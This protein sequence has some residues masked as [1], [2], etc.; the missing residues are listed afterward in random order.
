MTLQEW[1]EVLFFNTARLDWH[2]GLRR[3]PAN[4]LPMV[5]GRSG[6]S[7]SV[8]L[9]RNPDIIRIVFFPGRLDSLCE[10]PFP[11]GLPVGHYKSLT[12]QGLI[13]PQGQ[14]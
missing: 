9:E 13:C 1:Q 14:T 11:Q 4:G 2:C 10:S 6:L 5:R 8:S 12:Y 7:T 3:S